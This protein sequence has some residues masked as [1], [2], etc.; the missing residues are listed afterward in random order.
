MSLGKKSKHGKTTIVFISILLL[1]Y[2]SCQKLSSIPT[3]EDNFIIVP[4]T[5]LEVLFAHDAS[6]LIYWD[7]VTAVG[8]SYYKVYFGTNR[9][10]LSLAAETS[11]DFFFVDSL[12]YDST[13]YFQVTSVYANGDESGASNLVSAQPVN[14]LHPDEPIGLSVQGHNDDS[15]KYMTVIWSANLDGDLGGYEVYRDTSST[16]QTDTISFTNLVAVLKT[17]SFKDTTKLILDK[18]YHYRIIAFDFA[19]WRSV[20]SQAAGDMVLDRP[21]LVS[22]SNGATINSLNNLVFA[23][24]QVQGASGYIFYISS[25][26][27]GGDI[28]TTT[29]TPDQDS[30][31]YPGSS[32]NPNQL[33]YWHIAATTLDP[34]TPNSV[35]DVFSFALTQ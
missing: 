35:S 30:L 5:N 16:F 3:E 34:N 18:Q 17:N 23:F 8:F 21:T 1:T 32:L 31:V 24:S 33:Y 29:L 27:S 25:S 28:Y 22:P 26:S 2:S 15:G 7:Q 13:Y 9:A 20:P 12:S 4:P 10:N 11:N 19:H 6:V 14:Y